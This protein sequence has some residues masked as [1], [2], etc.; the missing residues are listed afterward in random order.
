MVFK[1]YRLNW[2]KKWGKSSKFFEEFRRENACTYSKLDGNKELDPLLVLIFILDKKHKEM[3][4][5][6]KSKINEAEFKKYNKN[7]HSI[8]LCI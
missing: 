6:D 3:Y 7:N 8:K 1:N 4:N 5:V 2:R